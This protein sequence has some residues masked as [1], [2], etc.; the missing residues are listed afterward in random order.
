L[1]RRNASHC[2]IGGPKRHIQ[3]ERYA[4]WGLKFVGIFLKYCKK[5]CIKIFLG[6][7]YNQSI[8]LWNNWR[9]RM[10]NNVLVKYLE[11]RFILYFKQLE[12]IIEICPDELWNKKCSGYTFSHQLVHALGHIFLWLRDEKINFFDGINDGINGLSINNELDVE[13]KDLIK[14]FY[15]KN[16]VLEICNGTKKQCKKWFKDKNDSWLL[17]SIKMDVKS[18]KIFTNFAVTIEM[19]EHIMYHIGHCEA[20]LREHNIK[21]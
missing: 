5:Y 7:K 19:S 14:E 8:N 10:E 20:I 4:K 15:S 3:P 16:N 17:L 21:K 6:L 11:K 1:A 12:D 13:S 9:N 2:F 18:E